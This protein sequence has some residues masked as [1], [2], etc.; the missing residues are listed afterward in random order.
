MTGK[1]IEDAQTIVHAATRGNLMTQHD[2]L[3]VVMR[4]LIEENSGP[5]FWR[6]ISARALVQ[7]WAPA[8]H[9]HE[10]RGWSNP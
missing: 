1:N 6:N 3:T 9:R 8:R 4:A 10:A 7:H 2:L 5:P